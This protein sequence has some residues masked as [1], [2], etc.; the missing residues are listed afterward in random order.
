MGGGTG[1]GSSDKGKYGTGG[2]G[3]ADSEAL[4][5]FLLGLCLQGEAHFPPTQFQ[6]CSSRLRVKWLT[7]DKLIK[8]IVLIW[9]KNKSFLT[10]CS[11][12]LA[13]DLVVGNCSPTFIVSN[14]LRLLINSLR[15]R[16]TITI[17]NHNYNDK[18]ATQACTG[19]SWG[20]WATTSW[21]SPTKPR[22]HSVFVSEPDLNPMFSPISH[23]PY[24]TRI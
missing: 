23:V 1:G 13:H 17:T 24:P 14:D 15:K 19:R 4:C 2:V 5:S 8:T 16:L 3:G 22:S 18:T 12:Y 6:A 21:Q 10:N 9:E 20:P 7:T 11:L